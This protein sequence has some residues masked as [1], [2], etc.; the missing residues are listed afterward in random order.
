MPN[1]AENQAI[2]EK[3]SDIPGE[4]NAAKARRLHPAFG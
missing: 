1:Q 4:M 3:S 2:P